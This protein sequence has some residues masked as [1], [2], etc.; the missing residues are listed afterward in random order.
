MCA[1]LALEQCLQSSQVPLACWGLRAKPGH[2]CC[3]PV[4][5]V[6]AELGHVLC[7]A[8]QGPTNKQVK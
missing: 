7:E 2:F 6:L 1:G 5:S 3:G 8:D 4:F